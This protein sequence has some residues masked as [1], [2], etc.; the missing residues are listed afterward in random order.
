MVKHLDS[1]KSWVPGVTEPCH[2]R[3]RHDAGLVPQIQTVTLQACISDGSRT[4][5]AFGVRA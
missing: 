4:T 3:F 2:T 5:S 1:N